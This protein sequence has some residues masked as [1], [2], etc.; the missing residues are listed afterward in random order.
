MNSAGEFIEHV[1]AEYVKSIISVHFEF[2]PH[3]WGPM[4]MLACLLAKANKKPL[5]LA[6]HAQIIRIH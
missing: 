3:E 4:G 5:L 2:L 6:R 1:N